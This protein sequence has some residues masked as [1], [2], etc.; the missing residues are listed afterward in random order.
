MTPVCTTINTKGNVFPYVRIND[1]LMINAPEKKSLFGKLTN[2][3]QDNKSST[4]KGTGAHQ[5]KYAL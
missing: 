1:A 4:F 2:K 5:E 3:K